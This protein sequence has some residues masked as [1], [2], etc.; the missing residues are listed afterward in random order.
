PWTNCCRRPSAT[1][2]G[3]RRSTAWSAA[4][5]CWRSAW[6]CSS[7]EWQRPSV[8]AAIAAINTATSPRHRRYSGSHKSDAERPGFPGRRGAAVARGSGGEQRLHLLQRVGLDLAD[9]LGGDAVF[10][11]QLLQGDLAVGIEPAALDDIARTV[12]QARKPLAQQFELLRCAVLALVGL[13]RVLFARHQVGRRRRRRALV[14][15]VG[16]GVEADVAAGQPR[17]HLQHLALG[18]VEVLRNGADLGGVEPAQALLAAAQVEEQ[19][20]LR[21]GRGDLD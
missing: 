11:G 17:L 10:V 18:D 7:G 3:T 6:C 16:G 12:V 20:A 19:L 21:L 1:R 13:R 5:P 9:A 2:A 4:W 14:V 15:L 8:G